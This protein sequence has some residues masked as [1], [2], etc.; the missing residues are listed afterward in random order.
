MIRHPLLCAGVLAAGLLDGPAVAVQQ[1]PHHEFSVTA[2]RYS[3]EPATLV[4]HRGDIV[5]ITLHAEDV[6]HSF[7]IDSYRIAKKALPGRAV[8]FEFLADRLGTFTFY[9]SLTSDE[10]CREM[11]GQFVV[12]PETASENP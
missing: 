7:V 6:A 12:Q 11:H 3:F 10:R 2:R 1:T 9:C 4:V 5:R 8:T